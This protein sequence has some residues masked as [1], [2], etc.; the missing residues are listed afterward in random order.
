MKSKLKGTGVALATPFR[1]DLTPDIQALRRLVR[2]ATEGGVDY[3][4]A[5]GTTA[6]SATL[7]PG[8]KATVLRVIAEENDGRLPLVAGIGGNNTLA[9]AEEM[10]TTDLAGYDAILSVSPYYNRPTQEGIYRH[11]QY[12]AGRAPLPIVMYN[13]PARTGSNMLPETVARLARDCQGIVGIKEA[14]GDLDQIRMLLD[15]VPRDF[16][17]ISGDDLTAAETVLAGGAGVIS[18]LGQALPAE[19]TTM[20]RLGLAGESAQA[21]DLSESLRPL[22]GLIFQEGNPAGV[23]MLLSQLGIC[24]PEVRLPLVAASKALARDLD[25]FMKAFQREKV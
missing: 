5:L 22:I 7:T 24:R 15:V 20:I 23:K 16:L 18:V 21:A 9:V 1:E 6:E 14:C 17:V 25:T 3:L 12:L 10:E 11:F 19:F 13:V 8:E 2:Y 4:V